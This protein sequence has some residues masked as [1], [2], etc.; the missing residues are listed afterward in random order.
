MSLQVECAEALCSAFYQMPFAEFLGE[1]EE[2]DYWVAWFTIGE[3]PKNMRVSVRRPRKRD[4]VEVLVEWRNYAADARNPLKGEQTLTISTYAATP[5][6]LGPAT[7]DAVVKVLELY[8]QVLAE[9]GVAGKIADL[10]DAPEETEET[11]E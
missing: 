9:E 7:Q 10:V 2:E 4:V 1:Q 6:M 3:R 8:R 5:A 11:A